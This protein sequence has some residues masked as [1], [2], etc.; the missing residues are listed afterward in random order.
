VRRLRKAVFPARSSQ[1]MLINEEARMTNDEKSPNDRI[2]NEPGH[3]FDCRSHFVIPS[4]F[5]MGHSSFS[6]IAGIF[7]A[8]CFHL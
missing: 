5:D 2:R 4:A 7:L 1:R 3:P 8:Q 6:S